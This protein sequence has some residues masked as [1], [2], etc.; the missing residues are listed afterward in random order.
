[1]H[2]NLDVFFMLSWNKMCVQ[3]SAQGLPF[4]FPVTQG[5]ACRLDFLLDV[6]FVGLYA[7]HHLCAVD[8]AT[9]VL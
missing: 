1:M 6:H 8:G 4:I 3:T 2:T 5:C 9:W 7:A